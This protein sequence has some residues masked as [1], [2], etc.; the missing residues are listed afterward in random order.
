MNPVER[1]ARGFDRWQQRHAVVGF[2]VAVVKKFGEDQA[3]NLVSLLAYY[4][5]VAVFPLLLLLTVTG[6]VLCAIIPSSKENC[7]TPPSP[8]FPSLA[9]RSISNSGS[10]PLVTPR[11]HWSSESLGRF[12]AHAA[13]PMLCRTPSTRCGLY[14]RW[15]GPDSR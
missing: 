15:T 12:T 1:V 8:N 14:P 5:F 3:G 10:L 9:A 2:P 7:S 11:C 6:V 13:S 4:A